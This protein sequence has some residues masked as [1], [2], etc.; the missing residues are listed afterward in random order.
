MKVFNRIA[1]VGISGTGKSTLA[2]SIS[3]VLQI[4]IIHMD[5]H[6]WDVHWRERAIE[7]TERTLRATLQ[8]SS[9][10]VEGYIHPCAK[11]KLDHAD[12]VL[13]LDYSGW[14]AM[15]GGFCRWWKYRQGKRPEMPEGCIEKLSWKYLQVM[16]KR[17][18][19]P[20]L[21]DALKGVEN[22]IVSLTSRKMTAKWLASLSD[23]LT[24]K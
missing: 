18:E 8:G 1:I 17:L 19:R 12:L 14:T 7:E 13:F 23:S 10:I 22:K 2:R 6:I 20:E 15:W 11:E 3:Q 5:E 4:P 21:I 9:W 16:R 24:K